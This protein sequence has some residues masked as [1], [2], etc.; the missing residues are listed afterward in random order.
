[1]SLEHATWHLCLAM[2]LLATALPA[3]A[4]VPAQTAQ[5]ARKSDAAS[6]PSLGPETWIRLDTPGFTLFGQVPESRLR[7]IA[8][9]LATYKLSLEWLLPGTR[10]SPRETSI[11]VFKSASNGLRYSPPGADLGHHLGV[12]PPYDVPNYVTV[13]APVDDPPLD[14]LY[15]AY[16]H[17][18]LDDNFPHLP[19]AVAEGLA[20]FCSGFAVT[21]TG[22][23][24]GVSNPEHARW[25][26]T[27]PILPLSQQLTLDTRAPLLA[28][29]AGRA[30]FM[31]GS[32]ALM[33][34]L[35]SGSGE[36]RA[37]LPP[38][39]EAVRRGTPAADAMLATYGWSLDRLQQE[40][41]GYIQR[42][43]YLPIGI[44][45]AETGPGAAATLPDSVVVDVD[46]QQLKQDEVFAAL[47]DLLAH[48]GAERAAVA[49]AHF[50]EALRLNRSQARAH[51]GLG[52]LR[53]A[54]DR[55]GEA[56]PF[57]ERAVAIDPDA[58]SCYLLAR[59]L[60]KLNAVA[61][62]PAAAPAMAGT[63]PWLARARSLLAKAIALRPRFAAPYVTLGATHILPD[64]DVTAGIEL[65]EKARSMLPARMDIAGNMVYLLLRKGDL[66]KA[67]ALVDKV[68][69]AGGDPD[70]LRSSR[71][72][73]SVYRDNVKNMQSVED[74]RL[75]PAERKHQKEW[76][77]DL[78][79]RL[80][81]LLAETK[82]PKIK[83]GI[84]E[85]LRQLEAPEGPSFAELYNQAVE[86]AN[87]RDYAR[88]IALLEDLQ[89]K[90]KDA[91]QALLIAT[92]L[93]R[94]R[95]DAARLQ[96]PVN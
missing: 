57:L 2:T 77:A 70:V 67:E 81:E 82:D 39:L 54:Q 16:A 43:R 50:Q 64:G 89:I 10:P 37:K 72:A 12:N 28:D 25:L 87:K 65:L 14:V 51:A 48:A 79:R 21:P 46:V 42:D 61:P 73:L 91:D 15:H 29:E 35:V 94:L 38:F 18:F 66:A 20:E 8:T 90:F 75:T 17:Q 9:K 92:L 3:D 6:R 24:L 34:Y 80:R 40:L 86:L 49:E 19:L 96:Q 7:L 59:S 84:E 52:Y 55:P 23:L 41:T 4:A 93:D 5:P 45:R 53:Y 78:A 63:P 33:H 83:A 13:A 30:S 47:G 76:S 58:I 11:F 74:S 31:A 27:H 88:A 44:Q 69:A 85:Q 32:W 56:I 1:L 22:A 36:N 26:K 68:I 95:Q 71:E 60:L 62:A